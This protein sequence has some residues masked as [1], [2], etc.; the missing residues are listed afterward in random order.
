[1]GNNLDIHPILLTAAEG[2]ADEL[3]EEL[4]SRALASLYYF[5]KV[6]MGFKDMTLAYHLPKCEEIQ[7]SI[8]YQRRMFLWARGTFKSS[9]IS[10]SYL[11][12]RNAGGGDEFFD[13]ER[14]EH[15]PRNRRWLLVGESDGRV[16]RNI[17]NI[18]EHLMKNDMLRW[19]FPE[20][21]PPDINKTVWRDDEILLPRSGSYDD[22]TLKAIGIGGK[23]TGWHGTGISYDDPIGEEAAKSEPE[24]QRAKDW[25][26][27]A[28]GLQEEAEKFEEVFAGT[29]WKHGRADLYGEILEESPFYID[30]QGRPHGVK[31]FAYD[32]YDEEGNS[33]FP[34]RLPNHV[35][36]DILQ[37][38]KSYLF[39]C[40]YRNTPSTPAGADFPEHLIKSY[41]IKEGP[42]GR[43]NLLV[44]SDGTPPIFL[45]QLNRSTFLDP[46]SGGKSAACENAI[47]ALGTAA[48]GRQ[49]VLKPILKNS[50]YRAIIEDWHNVNDQ[51]ICTMNKY[52]KAGAQKTIEEFILEKQLYKTCIICGKQH[53]KLIPVGV[54][55]PGGRDKDDRIRLFL[56]TT[57]E[58]GRLYLGEGGQHVQLRTQVVSF[59][60]YYL[61]DGA[62][63]LAYAVHESRR[64]STEEEMHDDFEKTAELTAAH[65]P[66]VNSERSYGGYA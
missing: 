48:D 35:L 11:L 57:V 4:R 16:R 52:E 56:S 7:S 45:Y 41:K 13:Y 10:K 63:A 64:P 54:P 60:H 5:A 42:D 20:L 31:C 9:I 12:W 36:A 49:F 25:W 43:R 65:P 2:K 28:T 58:E 47:I 17:V 26:K 15:D 14:E 46:S 40:Q 23:S 61:K 8:K 18:K 34:E 38:Q 33:T 44:P 30:D 39:S 37:R 53:R 22:N 62:D 50:G 1:M 59:P 32:I 29:R 19:L 6:V 66:R 3:R 24:M 51:F 55:P 21:I 27:L